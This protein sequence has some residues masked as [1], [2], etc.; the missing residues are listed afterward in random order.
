VRDAHVS[1][2]LAQDAFVAAWRGLEAFQGASSFGTWVHRIAV[3]RAVDHLRREQRSVLEVTEV[4]DDDPNVDPERLVTAR[5]SLQ[6]LR[7]HVEDLPEHLRVPWV[8]R[9][10]EELPYEEITA[11]LQIPA[12]TARVRVYRARAQ[13]ASAWRE[14]AP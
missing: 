12:A 14:D 6:E 4:V 5:I 1:E 3:N 9:E 7:Q 2:D 11:I 13:L 10:L 8:L